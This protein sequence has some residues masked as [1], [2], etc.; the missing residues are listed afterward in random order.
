MVYTQNFGRFCGFTIAALDFQT[1]ATK[2]KELDKRQIIRSE[3]HTMRNIS[4]VSL[5]L[6][7]LVVLSMSA[8]SSAQIGVSI[9]VGPPA[10]PVYEQP[11]C[12]TPGYMW[13][14]GYWAYDNNTG[15]YYWVP[16]TW[17]AAPQPGFLWTPPYW[18][19]NGVG[20]AFFPG[21]WGPHIGFYGGIGYG[22]GYPGTGFYGGRWQGGQ[23]FYNRSVTNVNVTNIHNTY[24]TTVINNNT[25]NHVSYNGGNGGTTAK[26]THEEEAA[27]HEQHI[28]PVA[29]QTQ[30][31]EAA[32][33][34]PQMRASQNHGKPPVAATSRPGDF[35]E[36]A[37]PAKEAGAPYK[38]E[39]Q[40]NA[41][42]ENNVPRPP[43]SNRGEPQT[44]ANEH[45]ENNVPRPPAHA[46]EVQ[47]HER[48]AAPNTGN[49]DVDKKYQQQ[50]DKLYNKMQQEHQNLQ[51]K[52]DQEHQRATQQQANAAKQQQMEQRHQQQ[53]QRMEQRHTQQMQKLQQRQQPPSR[54]GSKPGR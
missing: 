28:G 14:P 44:G 5:L 4:L 26:P 21:W 23:F 36:G 41:R 35:R 24:N 15:E 34:N 17:V 54:S 50:Q 43:E 16:G 51:A 13:T 37:V 7:T 9:S 47:P 33:N 3:E 18:G 22:F 38:P 10:L 20:F 39:P 2:C 29:A 45:P 11:P 8:V 31:Q 6:F 53:T 52:Q 27:A 46:S 42:S 48:P 49:P 30:H 32:R 1:A 12:P 40:S 19:W 25:N